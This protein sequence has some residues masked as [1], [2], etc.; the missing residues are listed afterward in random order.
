MTSSSRRILPIFVTALVLGSPAAA[1]A[2]GAT[3]TSPPNPSRETRPADGQTNLNVHLYGFSYHPDRQGVRR[4]GLDNEINLGLG[5]NYEFH[6]DARG[7]AFV[8]GGAYRDSG[9]NLAKIAGVGYQFKLGERWRVGGA[10]AGVSS[11][12]Y[13]RGRSFVAPLPIVTYDLGTV[14]VNAIYVPRY[15]EHNQFAVFGLYF[16]IPFPK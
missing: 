13:N 10:L 8:E 7:V 14:K 16:S 11:P 4:N 1:A 15:G 2:D 3:G 9:R 5:L 6:E 12:T